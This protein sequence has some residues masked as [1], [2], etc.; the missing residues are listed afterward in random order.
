MVDGLALAGQK[1]YDTT[2]TMTGTHRCYLD[3][4]VDSGGDLSSMAIG[5][6][7]ITGG[8]ASTVHVQLRASTAG[9]RVRDVHGSTTLGTITIDMTERLQVYVETLST[10]CAVWY[11]RPNETKWTLG[12]SGTLATAADTQIVVW[13]NHAVGAHESTWYMM[14][15]YTPVMYGTSSALTLGRELPSWLPPDLLGRGRDPRRQRWPGHHGRRHHRA[16]ELRLPPD[17]G[18]A[19]RVPQP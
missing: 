18:P 12:V 10:A 7:L 19:R 4:Q 8:G 3:F 17:R 1:Y 16:A 9:I 11:R 14:G 6:S 2:D 15:F 13:G 5:L